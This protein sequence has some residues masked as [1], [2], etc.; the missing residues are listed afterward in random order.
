MCIRPIYKFLFL[1]ARR[2][3]FFPFISQ[4]P[5]E[6]NTHTHGTQY[7]HGTHSRT[8]HVQQPARTAKNTR[9]RREC[10]RDSLTRTNGTRLKSLDVYA[11]QTAYT[12]KRAERVRIHVIIFHVDKF[13]AVHVYYFQRNNSYTERSNA[14]C[15]L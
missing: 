9:S 15:Q 10:V 8:A 14:Q 5:H 3:S 4:Y 13:R 6:H 1:K 2:I 11:I 7:T 12:R